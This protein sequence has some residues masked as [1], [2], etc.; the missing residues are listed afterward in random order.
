MSSKE[1]TEFVP[2][3]AAPPAAG[4]ALN[5]HLYWSFARCIAIKVALAVGTPGGADIAARSGLSANEVL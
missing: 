2:G 1:V 3:N 5:V 4:A